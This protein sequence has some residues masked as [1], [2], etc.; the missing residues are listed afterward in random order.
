[1]FLNPHRTRRGARRN[2]PAPMPAL[3]APP[4]TAPLPALPL[5]GIPQQPQHQYQQQLRPSNLNLA[6]LNMANTSAAGAGAASPLAGPLKSPGLFQTS[7]RARGLSVSSSKLG[8]DEN[9]IEEE[10]KEN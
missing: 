1:M 5:V 4:P 9:R 3:R 2:H 8:G 10:M 6:N 7:A